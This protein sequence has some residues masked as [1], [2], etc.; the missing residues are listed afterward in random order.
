MKVK[1]EKNYRR[2]YTL[3]DL[4]RAKMVISSV[5]EDE[6][7]VEEYAE[8]AVNE[9]SDRFGGCMEVIRATAQ[10]AKNSRAWDA[11][12]EGTETMDVWVEGLARTFD[13]YLE[14]GAYLSDI[15]ASGVT[16]YGH[17]MYTN[18]YERSAK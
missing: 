12:G 15:Y 8:Y 17:L 14:F 11:Y 10:T 16:L 2:Y 3:E 4:D 9:V 1:L 7:T 13:G 18:F 6:S 5:K